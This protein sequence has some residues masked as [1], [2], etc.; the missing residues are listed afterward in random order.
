MFEWTS[1]PGGQGP[2]VQGLSLELCF[3]NWKHEKTIGFIIF[4]VFLVFI[5][6]AYVS[7]FFIFVSFIKFQYN[8][9]F[10]LLF[11][12]SAGVF[13]TSLFL[14]SFNAFLLTDTCSLPKH[15]I[16]QWYYK[17][18]TLERMLLFSD[19]YFYFS[20]FWKIRYIRR[21]KDLLIFLKII[22]PTFLGTLHKNGHW[23]RLGAHLAASVAPQRLAGA[24]CTPVGALFSCFRYC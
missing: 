21:Q 10:V 12:G 19:D 20:C 11:G 5:D 15:W 9:L 22:G 23:P 24:P 14:Q 8:Q 18:F 6:F 16:F 13:L 4:V 2:G 7:I 3:F 17:V 1:V